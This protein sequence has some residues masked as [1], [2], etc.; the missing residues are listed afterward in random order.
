MMH[1]TRDISELLTRILPFMKE[2][3]LH[4][5]TVD[6]H[7]SSSLLMAHNPVYRT[8]EG[9]NRDGQV[10]IFNYKFLLLVL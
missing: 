3:G 5:V 1:P 10:Q 7:L 2:E 4:V 9:D 8:K 6:E